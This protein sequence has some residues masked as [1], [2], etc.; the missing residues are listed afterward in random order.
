MRKMKCAKTDFTEAD[1]PLTR[2]HMLLP[3]LF[4]EFLKF[5]SFNRF[6]EVVDLLFF[7]N[8]T[9]FLLFVLFKVPKNVFLYSLLVHHTLIIVLAVYILVKNI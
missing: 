6:L 1:L 5:F 7:A 4:L 2:R 8:L 9:V 3:L